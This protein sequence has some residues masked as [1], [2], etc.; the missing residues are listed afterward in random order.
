VS[1]LAIAPELIAE[2]ACTASDQSGFEAAVLDA[3]HGQIGF[4]VAFFTRSNTV[5][6]IAP[7]L[8]RSVLVRGR[9]HWDVMS[10]ELEEL[11]QLAKPRGGV[12]IDHD[13]LGSQLQQRR[14]YEVFM[15]PHHGH[16]TLFGFLTPRG[17]PLGEVVLGRSGTS[18]R[19][20]AKDEALLRRLLPTLSVAAASF[21]IHS[22]QTLTVPRPGTASLASAQLTKRQREVVQYLALGYTNA[23]IACA[24]GTRERT[25]RNQLSSAYEKL[26]V[27]S[28]A[29]AVG[30]LLTST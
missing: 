26:G 21:G 25:V 18:S 30:V 1:A 6:E 10:D 23:Q 5:S 13:V 20:H 4:D 28:R 2:M 9:E 22:E 12:L 11:L 14:Y 8:D 19:F 16:S 3:L 17:V 29:E 27:S 15:R 7:G 24:L